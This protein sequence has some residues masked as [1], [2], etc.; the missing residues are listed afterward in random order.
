MGVRK[1]IF[2]IVIFL[3]G[4]CFNSANPFFGGKTKK[5]VEDSKNSSELSVEVKNESKQYS[6][7]NCLLLCRG[8]DYNFLEFAKIIRDDLNFTD[9]FDVVVKKTQQK[10]NTKIFSKLFD[11]GISLLF[12]L[13]SLND[14]KENF[15]VQATMRD[16]NS[17]M[18]IFDKKVSTNN[19]N[20]I[21]QAH[22]LS[23]NTLEVLTGDKGVTLSRIAYCKMLSQHHKVICVSDYACKQGDVVVPTKAVNVAPSWHT[24]APLLFYSQLTR[25]NNRLMSVNLKT[26]KHSVVCDY[27][28]LNMQPSFSKD[29]KRV[30]V[31]LSGGRGNSELYLYDQALCK[32]MKRRVFKQLTRNGS[33]NVSPCM[34]PNDDLVFCSNYETGMPQIY[35]LNMKTKEIKRLTGGKGYCAAP[36]YCEKTNMLVYSRPINGTFQLFAFS[37]DDIN[38]I[39]ERRLTFCEGNKHEPSWSKCGRYIAFSFDKANAAGKKISQIAALNYHNGKIRTLTVSNEHKSFPRWC[40]DSFD[41]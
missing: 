39:Q 33:H 31:C 3:I 21:M 20:F 13:N 41:M 16:T 5:T 17:G 34:L 14:K 12:S 4:T 30:V 27:N 6:K 32:R 8:K 35:Y 26:G 2:W 28:G 29:G 7:L 1:N 22:E 18:I 38:N 24:K 11:K 37:L 19:K 10:I 36:S 15:I 25:V 9:Q 23:G 40:G